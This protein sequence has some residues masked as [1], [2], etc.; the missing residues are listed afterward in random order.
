MR[1]AFRASIISLLV[2]IF[3]S[4]NNCSFPLATISESEQ[5]S[6]SMSDCR[7]RAG[8]SS[9]NPLNVDQVVELINR[10]EKPVTVNCLISFLQAPLKIYAVNNQASAQAAAGFESPRIFIFNQNLILSVVPDGDGKDF[11][12]MSEVVGIFR[13]IKAELKF[14]INDIIVNGDAFKSIINSQGLS[15]CRGCHD[16]AVVA[17]QIT[18]GPAFITDMVLPDPNKRV[19]ASNLNFWARNCD[20]NANPFR[21][22]MLKVIM[23]NGRAEE[24]NFLAAPVSQ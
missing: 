3:A 2:I 13:S 10:I 6:T 4:F 15:T 20:A 14:P 9:L 5:L 8:E 17:D 19:P 11:V 23:I 1:L 16:N 21:C 24:S 12:E 18:T 7:L 22:E